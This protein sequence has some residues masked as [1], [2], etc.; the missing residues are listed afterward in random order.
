MTYRD[1]ALAALASLKD[2]GGL[3]KLSR[4]IEP[5]A[6]DPSPWFGN[7][8]E[9]PR[10][11]TYAVVAP[12]QNTASGAQTFVNAAYIAGVDKDGNAITPPLSTD[13]NFEDAA[14]RVWGFEEV[15]PLAPDMLTVILYTCKVRAWPTR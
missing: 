13:D 2:R 12:L 5:E 1:D 11:E 4:Y 6:D 9:R 3:V 10:V 8:N 7:E 15:Q 14:G